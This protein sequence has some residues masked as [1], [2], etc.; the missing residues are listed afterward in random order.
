MNRMNVENE[1]NHFY[2]LNYYYPELLIA[3]IILNISI[4]NESIILTILNIL[5]GN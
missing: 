4:I 1:L 5:Y 3:S 2:L